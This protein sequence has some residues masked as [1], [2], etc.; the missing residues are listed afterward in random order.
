M[1]TLL[2]LRHAKSSW[3]DTSLDDHDRPLNERGRRDAPRRGQLLLEE[4]LLPDL[5]L[6]STAARARRTAEIVVEASGAKCEM[7]FSRDFYHADSE[8]WIEALQGVSESHNRVMVVGHNPGLELLLES[9]TGC[10]ERL[11][12]AALACIT[13]D[14]DTWPSCTF[15]KL[16]E[17]WRPRDLADETDEG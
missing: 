6:C 4:S 14:I 2:I 16:L 12:T 5:I 8:T 13:F 17:L 11:P 10:D 15:G 3:R 1:K 9:L 7:R